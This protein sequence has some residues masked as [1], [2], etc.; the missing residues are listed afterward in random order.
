MPGICEEPLELPRFVRALELAETAA[1]DSLDELPPE[2][3]PSPGEDSTWSPLAKDNAAS[4]PSSGSD[5][6]MT[7][8]DLSDAS[9]SGSGDRQPRRQRHRSQLLKSMSGAVHQQSADSSDSAVHKIAIS[10]F[11]R[12]VRAV[13]LLLLGMRCMSLQ[14][15]S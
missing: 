9:T 7:S 13:P 8:P 5:S 6:I 14:S 3:N 15:K 11:Y 4:G 10:S 12:Q 1:P 2:T